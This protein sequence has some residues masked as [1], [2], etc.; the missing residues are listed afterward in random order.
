MQDQEPGEPGGFGDEISR[1]LHARALRHPD[2]ADPIGMTRRHLRAAKGRRRTALGAT[3]TLVVAGGAAFGS[4]YV[5]LSH[6]NGTGTGAASGANGSAPDYSAAATC[7][8]NVK[9]PVDV[10]RGATTTTIAHALFEAGVVKSEDAYINAAN[11][12]QGSADIG[13]GTYVVCP[14]ISGTNAVLEL[15][16][17]SNLSDA[18]QII[19]QPHE[20][21]K[22]VIAGLID[23][24][25]WKQADFDTAIQNNTIGLPAWSKDSL[26]G[27][28][29]IEG[30]LEPGT[31]ALVASDTPQSVLT[32][33]VANRMTFL[34]SID[35]ETKAAA[36][37][38]GTAH[39]TPEQVL[40]VGSIAEGE[41][42]DPDDGQKVAEGVYTRLKDNDYLGIDSTALYW[43]GH[44]PNG[45]LPSAA[46][47]QD[48]NNPYSTYA[49]HHGLPPT[50]VY[51]TSDDMIKS[52]LTPSHQG[53]Y[54]WCVTATGTEFFMKNQTSAFKNAC[55]A[56]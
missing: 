55:T 43:I 21:G 49:P 37:T 34:K 53:T 12:D 46:Q 26:T 35:F 50:P 5:G 29:T 51:D 40:T 56:K 11:H 16:K 7:A 33:M 24:R 52:A 4:G 2:H 19:V 45:K 30:M 14:G 10:P 47:V 27:Q 22:D 48:P 15:L 31:Y 23:K 28:F 36:L 42:T 1:M 38:C 20:W 3:A 41:V 54:Y 9:V 6:D 17:K 32:Q 25:K 39:C 44:L 18:S 8:A 13:A